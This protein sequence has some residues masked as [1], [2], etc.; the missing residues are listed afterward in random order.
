MEAVS[1]N[2]NCSASTSSPSNQKEKEFLMDPITLTGLALTILSPY[3]AKVGEG[4]ATRVG[5]EVFEQGKRLYKAIRDRFTQHPDGGKASTVLENFTKDPEEYSSNFENKL[6]P[7]LQQDAEF[8]ETLKKIIESGP[9]LSP[10]Q[11]II[12]RDNAQVLSN[13][14][15]NIT[16]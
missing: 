9:P 2:C 13:R 12:A 14:M 16:G 7:L 8:A 11:Q 15:S 5:D 4:F 6:L 3:I 10:Q 1:G